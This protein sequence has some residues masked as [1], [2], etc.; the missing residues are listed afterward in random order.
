M[1]NLD[2]DQFG[3][4]SLH[5]MLKPTAE[6]SKVWVFV[7]SEDGAQKRVQGVGQ[8][9]TTVGQLFWALKSNWSLGWPVY[10]SHITTWGWVCACTTWVVGLLTLIPLVGQLFV[11]YPQLFGQFVIKDVGMIANLW[12]CE[13]SLLIDHA[14]PPYFVGC[15]ACA[16]GR[17]VLNDLGCWR[18]QQSFGSVSM[19]H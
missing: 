7:V 3:A 2:E 19:S 18:D 16:L 13:S 5:H 9:G 15:W 12:L 8:V 6:Y 11:M 14:N 1:Q 17:P 4:Q 10:V